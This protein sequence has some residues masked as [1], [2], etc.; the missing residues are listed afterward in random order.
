MIYEIAD[1]RI[2]IKNR[3]EYTTRHCAEYLSCDQDAPAHFSVEVT[4]EEFYAEKALSPGFS[5]GYIENICL[6][7]KICLKA[8]AFGRMLLHASILAYDGAG[9]AFL[10]KSGTGKSTHSKLWLEH[11]PSAYI[12]N[13]DKPLLACDGEDVYAYGTPWK[14]KEKFGCKDKVRLKALCFLRQ[15]KQNKLVRLDDSTAV[16]LLFGQL[17]M[18]REECAVVKTLEYADN[19]IKKVPAYLLDCDISQEAV[20]TSFEGLIGKKFPIKEHGNED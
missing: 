18:P 2:D 19:I 4:E 1:L 9:Y 20:K 12:V 8:P 16:Q 14:G 15:S 11:I 10:G 7:R 5:D 3:C 17:L 6:Y 13:G